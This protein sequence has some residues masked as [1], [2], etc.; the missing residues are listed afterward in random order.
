MTQALIFDCDG[1]LAE[2]ER[3]G[4]RVAFNQMFKEF[5]LPVH[6]DPESYGVKLRIAGGKERLRTILDPDLVAAAGLPADAHAQEQLVVAWHKRKTEIYQDLVAAGSVVPR[7]GVRRLARAARAA[8]WR[9]AVASTSAE[10]SVRAVLNRAVGPELAAGISVLAGDVVARKKPAPDIYLLALET[11]GCHA[12]AAVAI[13]DSASGVTS[14]TGAGL[15]CLVTISEYTGNDDFTAAKI[16]VSE[17]GD[18]GL[19]PVTVLANPTGTALND[20][21]RL[22][23]ICAMLAT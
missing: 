22:E 17:L 11:L 12:D 1:V 19:P 13:E 16:V 14:A 18:P 4:H 3:D 9:L 20:F 15:A 23:H 2:T 21:V 8:G 7:T 5:G 6:W 10:P